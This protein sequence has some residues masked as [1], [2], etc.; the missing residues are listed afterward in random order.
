[1]PSGED[2][3]YYLKGLS[4]EG[5]VAAK[6]YAEVLPKLVSD[7]GIADVGRVIAKD[8]RPDGAT[9]NPFDTIYPFIARTG[10]KDVRLPSE[11]AAAKGDVFPNDATGSIV[12]SFDVEGLWSPK[13]SDGSRTR[14]PDSNSLLHFLN[15]KYNIDGDMAGPPRKGK[16]MYVYRGKG[17]MEVYTMHQDTD[18]TNS[19]YRAGF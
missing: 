19:Y 4:Y 8:P 7:L 6:S 2:I 3:K 13:Q 15:D 14:Q 12:V 5:E 17:K 10:V 9:P 16:T 11:A 18:A 1:M